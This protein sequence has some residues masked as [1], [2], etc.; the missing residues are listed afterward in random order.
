MDQLAPPPLEPQ[1][2]RS[3]AG[4]GCLLAAGVLIV[5]LGI[6]AVGWWLSVGQQT[7]VRLIQPPVATEQVRPE[8]RSEPTAS[9]TL[10]PPEPTD[11]APVSPLPPAPA[12]PTAT[13]TAID[14]SRP[15][16]ATVDKPD[17]D[18]LPVGQVG[19]G[20]NLRSAP[21]LDPANVLAQV[22]PGDR[23]ELLAEQSD[24]NLRW[25]QVRVVATGTDCVS[26]RAA[27]GST[28][29]LADSLIAQITNLAP[30]PTASPEPP[31]VPELPTAG[32]SVQQAVV[33]N[34]GNLRS[35]RVLAPETVLAQVC[36]DD[37]V[38]LLEEADGW[39]R[40]R[41]IGVA[42]DCVPQRAALNT[43]GWLSMSLLG[44]VTT[45]QVAQ[46]QAGQPNPPVPAVPEPPAPQPTSASV[47]VV[48]ALDE[49][50][51]PLQGIDDFVQGM[52][53]AP[54]GSRLAAGTT[55]GTVLIWQLTNAKPFQTITG[56]HSD[57][58]RAVAFSPD[59]QLLASGSDDQTV[60]IWRV[61]DGQVVHTL[62]GHTDWVRSVAFGP[63][64]RTLASASDDQTVR[65]WDITTGML[66]RT[67]E[68]HSDWVRV[69][70]YSPDGT[71][72]AS[73]ADDRTI[74]IW[75]VTT[76]A[77]VQTISGHSDWILSLAFSPDGKRLA[78]GSADL[79]V[80]LW[81]VADGVLLHTFSEPTEGITSLAFSPDGD[82]LAAASST[83]TAWIWDTRNAILDQPVEAGDQFIS[84]VSFAPDGSLLTTT[85]MPGM[86]LVRVWD[87]P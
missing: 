59:G 82:R 70:V 38:L 18:A 23:V 52:A 13:P 50:V 55:N 24:A 8:A 62:A 35:E 16:P 51:L 25:L 66:I 53:F 73:A 20:G 45:V 26:T 47:G 84:Y 5:L 36:P 42:P 10:L 22:C 64:G 81:R 71:R 78:S 79:T 56:A 39:A 17:P 86:E 3:R 14:P 40:I 83:S 63:D 37:T 33:A 4:L 12:A 6:G 68:Q 76:G 57:W 2:S 54:D 11:N 30:I 34:G 19:N 69:V 60:R 48:P 1:P 28:G 67:L 58:V 85:N 15:V 21:T 65:L 7:V 46:E 61:R 43:E 49:G 74:R 29:W 72:L 44:A 87:L 80:R 31:P 41:V 32:T 75:D 27:V 9:P 77:L